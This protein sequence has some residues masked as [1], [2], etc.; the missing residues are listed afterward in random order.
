MSLSSF[1]KLIMTPVLSWLL[2][3]MLGV[4]SELAKIAIIFSAMPTAISSYILAK[5][6]GGDADGMAQ[7]ITFQTILAAFSLPL[8][9]MVAQ[10]F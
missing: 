6:M 3:I 10:S 1:A 8:F 2:C 5:R 7:I 9:L 4:D